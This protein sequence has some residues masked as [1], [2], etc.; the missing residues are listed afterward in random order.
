MRATDAISSL[1]KRDK[2][3]ALNALQTWPVSRAP[4]S[5]PYSDSK[6]RLQP[7]PG[8]TK[9]PIKPQNRARRTRH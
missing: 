3:Y 8:C 6:S 1:L 4:K 7:L 2:E 9:S 5:R